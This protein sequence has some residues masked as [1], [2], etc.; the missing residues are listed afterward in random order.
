MNLENETNS[1]VTIKVRVLK[2]TLMEL[3]E[4][5]YLRRKGK[6]IP[7]NLLNKTFEDFDINNSGDNDDNKVNECAKSSKNEDD[8]FLSQSKDKDSNLDNKIVTLN[9]CKEDKESKSNQKNK[10]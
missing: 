4:M 2:Y 1:T 9:Y 10:S 6:E 7:S 5:N 8:S 3:R